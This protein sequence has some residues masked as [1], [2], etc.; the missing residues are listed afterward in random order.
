MAT[1]ESYSTAYKHIRLVREDGILEVHLHTKGD[2]LK[3]GGTI[4][5]EMGRCFADIGTDPDNKVVIITGTGADFCAEVDFDDFEPVTARAFLATWREAKRLLDN[6]L[7][8]EVP[9]IGAINGRAHVHAEIA[10]LSNIVIAADNASFQD[11]AHFNYGVVPG[12]GVHIY[13]PHLLGI[14][15][16]SYFLL[17]NQ[18]LDAQKALE[19]GIV[20]ELVPTEQLLPRAREL[21]R[22]IAQKPV[23]ARHFARTV[24]THDMKRLMHEQLSHG[25]ALEGLAMLDT[26]PQ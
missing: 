15:R 10:L 7:D 12:D 14:T 26:D 4:H 2:S 23:A 16:G 11:G 25:L 19:F 18:I 21:A 8:V 1:F 20:N 9:V 3:W 5:E 17:T 6:L 13:W 22:Q 24:L